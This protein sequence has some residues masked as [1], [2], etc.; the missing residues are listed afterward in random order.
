[1][2]GVCL[3]CAR[4][5]CTKMVSLF[6]SQIMLS[7]AE[8]AT[9]LNQVEYTVNNVT[10]SCVESL[11]ALSS[12]NVSLAGLSFQAQLLDVGVYNSCM[13]EYLE[14]CEMP[15]GVD[16]CSTSPS[17]I[18]YPVGRRVCYKLYYARVHLRLV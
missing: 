4:C 1:M 2:C 3:C 9:S 15:L 18:L 8:V 11:E 14:E 16:N 5:K 17:S 10:N 6:I 13:Y 12:E 7:E